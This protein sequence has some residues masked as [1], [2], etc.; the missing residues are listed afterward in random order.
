MQHHIRR[1]QNRF[2][3]F[4]AS[5]N[6]FEVSYDRAYVPFLLLH[7]SVAYHSADFQIPMT[8]LPVQLPVFKMTAL[9]I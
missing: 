7:Y 4:T 5:V 3:I 8:I 6:L 1:Q 9:S 2:I